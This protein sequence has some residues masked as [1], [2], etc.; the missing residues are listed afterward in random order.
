MRYPV[1]ITEWGYL[2]ESRDPGDG[3]LVGTAEG[4]G[5]PLLD[6]LDDLGAGWVACWWDDDWRPAM[7][8]EGMREA[9]GYG[10]FVLG[11]LAG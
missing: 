3:Y 10:G 6:R 2:E 7:F 8:G 9:T 4:Y 1:L 11:E 5:R